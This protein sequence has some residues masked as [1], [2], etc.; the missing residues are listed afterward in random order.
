M[1][2][3]GIG[4]VALGLVAALAVAA[5]LIAP[6]D[7][8][9]Q[10]RD[11][12]YAPPTRIHLIDDDGMLRAPFMYHLELTDQL[13]RVYVE[14]RS[15]R[16]SLVWFSG[17]RLVQVS[18]PHE[19][20]LLLLGADQL[21]RDVFSRVVF[22]ARASLSVALVAAIAALLIGAFVGAVAGVSGGIVDE[23]AM[24]IA[25]FVLM[26][27]AL[28][29]VLALRSVTP[30]V[31]SPVVIF[32]L[33]VGVFSIVGWPYVARGV[34][35][36]VMSEWRQDYTLAARSV[37]ISTSRLVTGHVLPAHLRVPRDAGDLA[38]AGLHPRGSN[39]VICRAWFLPSRGELGCHASGSLE[40]ARN[41]RLPMASE[42]SSRHHWCRPWRQS[43]APDELRTRTVVVACRGKL[44]TG[45][46][47]LLI[48]RYAIVTFGCRVNQADSLDIE[49][50]LRSVGGAPSTPDDADLVIV[51][52]C[53]VTATADHGARQVIRR[54]ARKNPAARIVAT[55]C[56]ATRAG[57]DLAA[58]P[59]VA[60]VIPNQEKPTLFAEL[61]R[62]VPEAV[63]T[64]AARYGGGDGAC[65][66]S[67]TP[68]SSGR[69]GYTLRVQTG[70]DETC[71]YCIIPST[72]GAGRSMPLESVMSEVDRFA[73]EG[74]K[75][76]SL[77]GGPHWFVRPRFGACQLSPLAAARS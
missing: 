72:R 36:I 55:G 56:Y 22:G 20:P 58:L 17:G 70:C 31:L 29:V 61:E 4:V 74:F 34:R 63:T 13:E 45:R 67:I 48:V 46:F 42:S 71:A 9:E 33:M 68:G 52:T 10:F 35:A 23:V 40:R 7:P 69:T 28:Y 24:R 30:L 16:Q 19:G 49:R 25:D 60:A 26:L 44:T 54:I 65:G 21:G 2:L 27:P 66:A 77:T 43:D 18:P 59:G 62:Q 37:G 14:D 53:S 41:R 76:A 39:P 6:N 8:S 50:K 11:H 12:L 47:R 57:D 32:A 5:P 3:R 64:T 15:R 38:G 1:T 73:S 75:E 51:N